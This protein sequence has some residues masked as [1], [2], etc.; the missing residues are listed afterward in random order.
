[1]A[2]VASSTRCWTDMT[3]YLSALVSGLMVQDVTSYTCGPDPCYNTR[4]LWEWGPPWNLTELETEI[5]NDIEY[6]YQT[7]IHYS[8]A[9]RGVFRGGYLSQ[10]YNRAKVI[11]LERYESLVF[12]ME[13]QNVRDFVAHWLPWQQRQQSQICLAL[14]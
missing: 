3:S 7:M 14:L 11:S 12:G 5:D 2:E 4:V 10:R 6:V 1:M 8:V 9:A 13:L